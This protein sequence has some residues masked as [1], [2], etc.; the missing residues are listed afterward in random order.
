MASDYGLG[1]VHAFRSAGRVEPERKGLAV[2]VGLL[3]AAMLFLGVFNYLWE[4]WRV[5]SLIL[6][7]LGLAWSPAVTGSEKQAQPM[8]EVA[9]G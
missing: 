9:G 5:R 8:R 7:F 1:M 2:G 4:D 6:A 3:L